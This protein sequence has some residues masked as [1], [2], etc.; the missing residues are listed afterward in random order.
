MLTQDLT[1]AVQ[2]QFD[3][4]GERFVLAVSGGRDSMALLH[5]VAHHVPRAR[6]RACV[7]TFNH[8]IR[9]EAAAEVAFVQAWCARHGIRCQAGAG[10]APARVVSGGS[11]EAAARELRYAFLAQAAAEWGAALIVMAHHA[12]DQAETVLLHVLRGASL[13]G[14]KGM[15][16][17]SPHPQQPQL[18]LLRPLLHVP[19]SAI[20]AYVQAHNIPYVEDSSNTDTNYTRNYLRQTVMPML[21][22]INPQLTAA[23]VRLSELAQD[24]LQVS[25]STFQHSVLP[26]ITRC[27][28]CWYTTLNRY[29][30]MPTA[31]QRR[32]VQQA[33]QALTGKA[34]AFDDVERARA[35]FQRRRTSEVLRLTGGVTVRVVGIHG[36]LHALI[37][38]LPDV[39][40]RLRPEQEEVITIEQLIPLAKGQ[41]ALKPSL[42][43]YGDLHVPI[44][45]TIVLRGRRRGDVFQPPSLRGHRVKLAEW[46]VDQKIPRDVRDVIPLIVVDDQI[47]VVLLPQ[48]VVAY[49]FN[50]STHNS[51][52]LILVINE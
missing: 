18:T 2:A 25:D 36:D 8:G 35:V 44:N 13:N 10:D 49:P 33:Y 26:F 31:F 9:P 39:W 28:T 7:A 16:V 20:N 40:W 3:G 11:L 4:H 23:L 47:G 41:L 6:Q 29:E 17:R 22:P 1:Q 5:A 34:L 27:A 42:N 38:E 24:E 50:F 51:E 48:P 12:D 19:R 43:N 45:A 21:E 37:G 52:A 32:F 15:S 30:R 14:L 46:M